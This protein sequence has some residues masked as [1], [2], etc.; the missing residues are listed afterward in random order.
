MHSAFTTTMMRLCRQ[1]PYSRRE[2]YRCSSQSTSTVPTAANTPASMVRTSWAMASAGACA[3]GLEETHIIETQIICQQIGQKDQHSVS[4]A[5]TGCPDASVFFDH[6]AGGSFLQSTSGL[7]RA[8][9]G[10]QAI[11]SNRI[12]HSAAAFNAAAELLQFCKKEATALFVEIFPVKE[13]GIDRRAGHGDGGGILGQ[14]CQRDGAV[15]FSI[16]T[17]MS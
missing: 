4:Q 3:A 14:R 6:S 7:P 17:G 1:M 10:A 9:S 5:V 12:P 2:S 13:G 8:P 16:V 11:H 15:P